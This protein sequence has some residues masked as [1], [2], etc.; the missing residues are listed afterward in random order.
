MDAIEKIINLINDPR[1][2]TLQL[3]KLRTKSD[4]KIKYQ[5]MKL[6]KQINSIQDQI[7]YNQ[8]NKDQI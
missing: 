5:G 7:H 4:I 6:K 1:P 3:K 2:N 8:N